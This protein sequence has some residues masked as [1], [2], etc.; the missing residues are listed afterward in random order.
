M[1]TFSLQPVQSK[2][3]IIN[4]VTVDGAMKT[5]IFH[6]ELQSLNKIIDEL[7]IQIEGREKGT[8]MYLEN[9]KALLNAGLLIKD[10]ID[11][12][13]EGK[14]PF[15]TLF[16]LPLSIIFYLL[17]LNDVGEVLTRFGLANL[18]DIVTDKNSRV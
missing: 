12:I 4:N 2:S 15:L 6:D 16:A 5:R 10:S 7:K 1:V 3:T 14:D 11:V 9:S 17:G 8:K 13:R 18:L